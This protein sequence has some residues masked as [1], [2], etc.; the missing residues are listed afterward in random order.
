MGSLQI[1]FWRVR[2]KIAKLLGA[3]FIFENKYGI[4]LINSNL[5]SPNLYVINRYEVDAK[6]LRLG[7]DALNDKYSLCGISIME[8]PHF[9]FMDKLEKGEDISKS[10]YVL[11]TCNGSL[12]GRTAFSVNNTTE[13]SRFQK[14]YQI[15]KREIEA[16]DIKPVVVYRINDVPYLADGKH[17]AALCGLLG[18]KVPCEEISYDFLMDSTRLWIFNKMKEHEDK[19]AKNVELFKF[20]L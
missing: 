5:R 8:S 15:K 10:D 13:I 1:L 11:R 17:R 16:G 7:F 14:L 20:V 4:K 3:T 9:Y 18:V 6:D 2:E 12:D 19:Y